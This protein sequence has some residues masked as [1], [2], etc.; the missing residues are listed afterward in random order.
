MRPPRELGRILLLGKALVAFLEALQQ[1]EKN[2]KIAPPGAALTRVGV[3]SYSEP[4]SSDLQG[5]SCFPSS[6]GVM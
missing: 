1:E 3:S 5:V 2:G 4:V 6:A